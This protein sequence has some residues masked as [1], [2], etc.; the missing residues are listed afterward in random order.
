MSGG[1]T[2]TD[3][4]LLMGLSVSGSLSPEEYT[5]DLTGEI[6]T[7]LEALKLVTEAC[8]VSTGLSLSGP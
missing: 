5:A 1:I 4:N 8:S 7:D 3:P 6:H 2:C